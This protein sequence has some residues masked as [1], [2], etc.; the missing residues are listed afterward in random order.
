MRVCEDTLAVATADK[1]KVQRFW[2][3]APCGARHGSSPRGSPDFFRE[4][5]TR[6]DEL[7]PYIATF[8]DFESTRDRTVLEIGVGLGSDFVRFVRAGAKATGVDLTQ[9]AVDLV[10][11]R[12]ELEGLEATLL[13]ADA[14]QLPFPDAS[15]E[16]V[17]SW[18]VLHH[19]P[20]ADHALQEAVRVLRPGGRLCLMLYARHSWVTAGLWARHAL[21]RGR[22]WH[23]PRRVLAE[24]L[25]SSGTRGY[26]KAELRRLLPDLEDLSVTRVGTHT[27]RRVAGPLAGSTAR[28]LGFYLIITGRQAGA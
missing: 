18:G 12:L 10:E 11:R 15:F 4:V 7:E 14:E 1:A 5:A 23:G 25:E 26:T 3:A 9:R 24:H 22:P 8:A 2:E 20:D 17:Y 27:D 6:R 21:L 19:T 28:W 16:V 13:Q